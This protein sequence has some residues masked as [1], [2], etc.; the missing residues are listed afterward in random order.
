M[1]R[2]F[3][4]IL[5]VL[6]AAVV[7]GSGAV[8]VQAAVQY[9]R[10]HV[11]Q[12]TRRLANALDGAR[13]VVLLENV[14]GVEIARKIATPEEISR[15]RR[16]LPRFPHLFERWETSLCFE[17]HHE[18]KVEGNDGS[19]TSFLI[20]FTCQ[21]LMSS[22]E[23][24]E[25][26]GFLYTSIPPSLWKPLASFFTSVGMPPKTDDEYSAILRERHLDPLPQS[27]PE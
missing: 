17:P 26:S 14:K 1:R 13:K 24:R 18:I 19:K 9:G 15:L 2:A 21:N 11:W 12:N 16:S 4:K 25:E 10:S 27:T 6:M 22:D 8:I 5:F 23:T 3:W 20:C 7:L